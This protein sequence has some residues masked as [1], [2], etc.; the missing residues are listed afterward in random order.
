MVA[1]AGVAA[2]AE[3]TGGRARSTA[4]LAVV[5]VAVLG[6]AASV[7][8]Q[9]PALTQEA[10]AQ[11][12]EPPTVDAASGAAAAG[13]PTGRILP[14]TA[15]RTTASAPELPDAPS[16][17]DQPRLS[18]PES[19]GYSR[20]PAP[21]AAAA[22]ARSFSIEEIVST[23]EPAVAVVDAGG[24]RG[25]GFF[26]GADT[27]LTNVHVVDGRAAVTVRL[28]TGQSLGA[29]VERQM[30]SADVAVLR[31]DQPHPRRAALELGT[32]EGVR[33][34]QEVIAIGAP[35]GLQ[36]TAT[37]GIVSAVRELNGI[38]LVQTDAAINPGNSGGP[39][40]DRRGRVIGINTMGIR[41]AQAL[42]FAV[43]INHA[44]SLVSGRPDTT[45]RLR[46][47]APVMPMAA[48][49][50]GAD[51]DR[52]V[53]QSEL[54]RQLLVLAGRADQIDA[55]WHHFLRNCLVQPYAAG[56]AERP[57]F[58]IRET[59]PT[60]QT[61]DA[62]CASVLTSLTGAVREFSEAMAAIG[63]DA[64]RAGVYPGV[65][66]EARR[67]HRIDWSGWDR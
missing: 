62:W 22:V 28:S 3:P 59:P 18:L 23:A 33:A 8:M 27:V 42:G 15:D 16:A 24:A 63:R 66:R 46:A 43:A 61:P 64:R 35:L 39:L 48:T 9:P 6:V 41:S 38:V 30:R 36:S 58:P 19:E 13:A 5:A 60:F 54:E 25:T 1:S 4:L 51:R 12:D 17:P 11:G 65:L 49:A 45:L 52:S 10:P 20:P 47:S 37:R 57:W 31:T 53:G 44:T 14:L 26:I 29:R 40:L 7:Y 55:N 2:E 67:R 21:A 34:G 50:G 32:I 56:D